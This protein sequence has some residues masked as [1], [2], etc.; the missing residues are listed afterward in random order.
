MKQF[1][2]IVSLCICLITGAL[3]SSAQTFRNPVLPFDYSD[4]DVCAVGNDFF[5]TASSFNCS[6]GLP[7]LHS[8]DL[9]NWTIINYALDSVP[10]ADYHDASVAH[11]KAVW[12]PSIRFNKGVYYILWGD[13]DQ[14]LFMVRTSNPRARWSEP[15]LIL[16]G[17]GMIDPCPIWDDNGKL[18]VVYALAASR[19]KTNS[20]LLLQ[21]FDTSKWTPEGMPALIYDGTY[22][23]SQTQLTKSVNHTIEGPKIY[24]RNGFYYILA[25][26]GGVDKGWQLA[27]RS[28]DIAGPY[29]SKVVMM[30][31]TT[32]INGP[33]QG[34]WVDT[35]SG[36]SWFMHFQEKQPFGRVVHLNPVKWVDN[37]PVIGN[38]PD[39]RGWGM[40][41]DAANMPDANNSDAQMQ[42]SDE[43]D[44][45]QLGLQWQW[46]ANYEPW[47]GYTTNLGFIRIYSA[48]ID[49]NDKN[50]F[51]LPNMLLQKV[52]STGCTF[53][54][55]LKAV[56]KDELS[57]SGIVVMG[58]DYTSLFIQKR[59]N[60]M[61]LA[62][63]N[64]R[65]AENGGGET[66]DLVYDFKPD[67]NYN[68]GATSNTE[69]EL[70]LRVKIDTAGKCY[71]AYSSDGKRFKEI[72][73]SF[74]AREGKWIGTKFGLFSLTTSTSARGW[75]D[76][77]WVHAE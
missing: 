74:K 51:H 29:E 21:Q 68:T 35:P 15:Q 13:P 45:T 52:P 61:C 49:E 41:M 75:L 10:G 42:M 39:G 2:N 27:L 43:F 3:Y 76:C 77:D 11:G 56:A 16:K 69:L 23:Q 26:A 64:C 67:K 40:P 8:T 58:L 53:T 12:A 20:V 18:Y 14:G 32:N 4:P 25:P 44:S 30:Q 47:F 70:Y 63:A 59:G 24:K 38:D 46:Q 57:R 62:I 31:G 6:P 34:G 33:H 60:K 28:K 9:V 73:R 71:F 54:V 55:K 7:V 1:L 72:N 48:M 65:D 17:K 36:E 50:M 5:L 22:D 19:A 37:W 66:V